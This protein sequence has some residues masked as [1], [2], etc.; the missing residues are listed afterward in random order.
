MQL[1]AAL[2]QHEASDRVLDGPE[3]LKVVRHI[4]DRKAPFVAIRGIGSKRCIADNPSIFHAGIGLLDCVSGHRNN[5][6]P[7]SISPSL[8]LLLVLK[9]MIALVG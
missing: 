6:H 8:E 4:D 9:M 7:V 3:V 1:L 5:N 2:L